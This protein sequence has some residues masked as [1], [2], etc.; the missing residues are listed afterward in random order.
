VNEYPV[1]EVARL[2]H[3]SVRTLHGTAKLGEY[4]EEAR[5]RWDGT[6]AWQQSRQRCDAGQ[7]RARVALGSA[8]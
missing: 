4:A 6:E 3:V 8:S 1:G 2:A 7:R 5:Q